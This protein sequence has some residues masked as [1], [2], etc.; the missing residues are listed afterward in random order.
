MLPTD[1]VERI[2]AKAKSEGRPFNRIL[3]DELAL[4]PHLDR[5]VRL[6][7]PRFP[8]RSTLDLGQHSR[9]YSFQVFPSSNHPG[10]SSWP[11]KHS[12]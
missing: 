11:G 8:L 7:A 5:Q 2:E 10:R 3:V 4:F 6:G 9:R 1:V 12:Q